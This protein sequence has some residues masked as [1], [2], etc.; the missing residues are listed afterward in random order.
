MRVR[1]IIAESRH[2]HREALSAAFDAEEDLEVIAQVAHEDA[3]ESVLQVA[4][5]VVC[6]GDRSSSRDGLAVCEQVKAERPGL[7]VLLISDV[8]DHAVLLAAVQAGVDGYATMEQPLSLII[9]TVRRVH[10]GD[11]V[12]P[13]GMLGGLLRGLTIRHRQ[14]DESYERFLRLTTREKQ[15]LGLLVQ[16]F[17]NARIADTLV[18]SPRTA[19]THVQNVVRKLGARSRLEA[20]ATASEHGWLGKR[21]SP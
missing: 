8:Q 19:R 1:L 3:L 18:I 4:C 11:V 20:A 10:S 5:N 6:V 13:S 15:V 12:V 7:R 16:G 14:A 17:G 2:L 21:T 9:D